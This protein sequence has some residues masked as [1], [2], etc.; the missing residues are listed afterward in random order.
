MFKYWGIFLEEMKALLP[1]FI[2]FKGD[3]TI[4]PKKYSNNGAL[5]GLD[6]Q[7]I[8]MITY[9][10]NTFS[11]NNSYRKVWTFEGYGIFYL[12][13][14]KRDIIVSDFLFPWSRLNLL[15]LLLEKPQ[16][17]A[18][19]DIFFEVVTYFKYGKMEEGY[20]MGKHLLDQIKS[21]VLPITEI[22]YPGYELLFMFDNA[23]SHAIYA[24]NA[25]QVTHINK[26]PG[27][28]EFFFTS[29][30]VWEHW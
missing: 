28:Q 8:I 4:L 12:K 30:L 13:G 26:G 5:R 6:W 9:D 20:W 3:S 7:P 29:R 23:I 2:K 10:E 24:K 22:L 16:E 27:R 21:K 25:L 17:L 15:F 19:S 18:S 1:Y 11:A 14:K